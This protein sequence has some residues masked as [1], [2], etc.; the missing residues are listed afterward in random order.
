MNNQA[1]RALPAIPETITVHL[2]APDQPAENVTLPFSEYIANVASSE[3][4]PTWPENALRANILAEVSFALNRVYTQYY[5]SRG[6][7]FDVTSSTAYDQSFVNGRGIFEN[8]RQ[9]T[10]ELFD[11]YIRRDENVEPLF[12]QYCDGI[13]V[14][15]NGLSQ[16]GS[17]ELANQGYTPYDILR[18]YYG[19]DI[20][21][22]QDA[23]V[24]GV[25]VRAPTY[26]LAAGS[27][28]EYV[29]VIQLRLNRI[30][31]N[32]PSIPKIVLIDGI[33]ST[34]TEAA[35]RQ[36]QQIFGL[37]Q[38]G[39]V[40]KATWY[41]IQNL[42][43]GVKRLTEL[44]SEG[45]R[46]DEVTQQLPYTLQEGA[47]GV[48]VFNLQYYINFLSQYYNT[49]PPLRPD[50]SFGPLTKSAVQDLQRT[51][52]LTADGI[53]GEATWYALY[54]AYLGI[55]RTIPQNYV[56]GRTIPYA[57]IP[58]R[59]GS[60]S[61][62]VRT[63]QQYLNYVSNTYPEIPAVS[64]TGYFGTRTQEAVL[65]FQRLEG[66]SPTGVVEAATWQTLTDLYNV[67]YLGAQLGAG[68]YPGYEVGT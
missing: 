64:T 57:G 23:P 16:W 31:A 41:A 21:I 34:D 18:F 46:L 68:Q 19:D 5:R 58:L 12:A 8:I 60:E 63:L 50:G 56:E 15:C 48:P 44:N 62:T 24:S 47:T 40:D 49:I 43:N 20:V 39:V 26:P 17:V 66:L 59:L 36:F 33:F 32:Y 7:D 6:Y 35:V 27:Y 38:T 14:T 67:L 42:Y 28:G 54:N 1:N 11:D 61:E 53:V 52:G 10:S 51:F 2:G 4:Y 65:A 3:I 25:T 22:E 37:S 55:V 30:S 29:R 9:L 45:I 13:R